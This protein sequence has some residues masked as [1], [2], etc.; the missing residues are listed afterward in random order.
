MKI[1]TYLLALIVSV[2]VFSAAQAS[3]LRC[4][5]YIIRFPDSTYDG[6]SV[7]IR[8]NAR[9]GSA[10]DIVN[11]SISIVGMQWGADVVGELFVYYEISRNKLFVIAESILL[12]SIADDTAQS[13]E[14]FVH[15]EDDYTIEPINHGVPTPE[16]TPEPWPVTPEPTNP[17]VGICNSITLLTGGE[18]Y[19]LS[20]AG[21]TLLRND[22]YTS[23]ESHTN[24][25]GFFNYANGIMHTGVISHNFEVAP[26]NPFACGIRLY[27]ERWTIE[28]AQPVVDP[29]PS[30][31]PAVGLMGIYLPIVNR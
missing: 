3:P 22:T 5:E 18:V 9:H 2:A 13:C 11:G 28:Y 14:L 25:L 17:I 7:A 30:P 21:E 19:H 16:P 15:G 4:N 27:N 31:D 29:N 26:N 8:G 23:L 6:S 12:L 24:I 20:Y 1:L 10:D